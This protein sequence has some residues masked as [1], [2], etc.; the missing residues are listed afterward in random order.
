ME[1]HGL[2]IMSVGFLIGED[3]PLVLDAMTIRLIMGQLLH[4]VNWGPLDYLLIDLP[5]GTADVQQIVVQ[6]LSLAGAVLVVTPQDVAHLDG[7]KAVGLF[8]RAGVPILG[9]VEN[10][11]GYTCPHCG[12]S[13]DIFPRVPDARAIWT[14]GV[15]NLG[16]VPLDPSVSQ[17]GD[18]GRPVLIEHAHSPQADAFRGIAAQ[19]A[20]QLRAGE[21]AP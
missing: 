11:S 9:V 2:K 4:R 15:S 17:G 16:R 19:V 18:R 21:G 20:E 13:I 7:K 1:R 3:Q 12:G 6:E 5:P 8:R 10:M 14:M